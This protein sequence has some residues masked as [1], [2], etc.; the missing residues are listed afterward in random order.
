M[1]DEYVP[2]DP[3]VIDDRTGLKIRRSDSR[4]QW[5]GQIVHKDEWEQR[6]PQELI[7][8]RRDDMAVPD[9]RPR[10][11]HVFIGPL[12]TTLTADHAAGVTTIAVAS[13]ARMQAGDRVKVMLDSGDTFEVIVQNIP[14]AVSLVLTHA[15]PWAAST[16]LAVV[17]VTAM[18]GPTLP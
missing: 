4:R 5:D 16:G 11:V 6:H 15:L 13:S 14:D 2:N 3:W 18:A 8:A 12:T 1:A 9:P 17:D 7:K 10:P